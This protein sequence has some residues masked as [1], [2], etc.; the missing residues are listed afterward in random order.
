MKNN[1]CKV[2]HQWVIIKNQTFYIIDKVEVVLHLP[3]YATKNELN[4]TTGVDI[5][6]LPAKII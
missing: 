6:D 5:S 2:Y 1:C 3:N 4:Y